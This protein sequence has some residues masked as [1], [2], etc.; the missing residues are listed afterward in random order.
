MAVPEPSGLKEASVEIAAAVVAVLSPYLAQ[1]GGTL[2]GKAGEGAA[3]LIGDLYGLVRK[4]FDT[5]PDPAARAALRD[6]EVRPAEEPIQ[7]AFVGVLAAKATAD[8]EFAQELAEALR[9][10]THGEPV[11]QQFLIQVFGGEVGK[12]ISIGQARDVYFD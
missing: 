4:K 12:I 1:A 6:L 2:A 5:D 9:Q 7:E 10:I 3:A 11:T 8:S